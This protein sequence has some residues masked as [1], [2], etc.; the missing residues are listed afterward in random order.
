[1]ESHPLFSILVF[2]PGLIDG[3]KLESALCATSCSFRMVTDPI[4]FRAGL[5]DRPA[6][7]LGVVTTGGGAY[8]PEFWEEIRLAVP[9]ES[10]LILIGGEEEAFLLADGKIPGSRFLLAPPSE[11]LLRLTLQQVKN[12]WKQTQQQSRTINQLRYMNRQFRLVQEMSLLLN[13]E[14]NF[15]RLFNLIVQQITLILKADRTS[16]FLWDEESGEL[17]TKVAEGIDEIIRVPLHAGLVG[18]SFSQNR[19]L[20]ISDAWE[21]AD[22]DKS[23]DERYDYRTESVICCPIRNRQDQPKGVLQIINKQEGLF[24]QDDLELARVCAAQIGVA[25]ESFDLLE[26][27]RKAFESFIRTLTTVIDAKH[28]LTAGHSH[29]VTEYA[30]FLGQLLG[31]GEQELDILKYATL[32][33]DIGKIGVPDSILTKKGRFTEEERLAM[34]EHARWTH[35]ILA[36]IHLPDALKEIPLMASCHHER[37]DGSGYPQ[38]LSHGQIPFFSRIIAIAD[39]FDALTSLRDYPKYDHDQTLGFDPLTMDHA[40]NIIA[41]DKGK[42]FDSQI[43]TVAIS[44]RSG[45]EALWKTLYSEPS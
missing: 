17:W 25:L 15:D 38:A 21:H 28:P 13:S 24:D 4:E 3:K 18:K 23:W 45:M 12:D 8:P 7:V 1:M 11:A 36:E 10:C 6:V 22:F 35:T 32:L 19:P 42:H 37:V 43:A 14:K 2:N 41:R 40:F 5:V 26:Q 27:S 44:N 34:N 9:E 30:L 29:R 39:V 20:L 33:H 31:L 16:L